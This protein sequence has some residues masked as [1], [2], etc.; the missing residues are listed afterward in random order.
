MKGWAHQELEELH[1]TFDRDDGSGIKLQYIM[2]MLDFN[3]LGDYL[4][5][6]R[7]IGAVENKVHSTSTVPVNEMWPSSYSH[8]QLAVPDGVGT[9]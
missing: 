2:Y 8:E 1:V 6:P 9:G 3:M 4:A 7:A 5:L